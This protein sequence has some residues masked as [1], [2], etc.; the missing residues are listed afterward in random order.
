MKIGM[1]GTLSFTLI[2]LLVIPIMLFSSLNP[3]NELN[4]LTGATLKIDLSM[5]Y[6]NGASK[7][8]TLFQNSKPESIKDFFPD[9]ENDW[10]AY[11][12]DKSIETKN[13]PQKQIQKIEFFEESDRNWGLAKPHI[14]KLKQTLK[15]ARE[16]LL[17][18]YLT[19]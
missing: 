1:G 2:L 14:R 10:E 17:R 11:N 3:T 19:K 9:H 16:S 18:L 5:V 6:Q 12:Y 7:N 4:N 8:Y 15:V 13:F